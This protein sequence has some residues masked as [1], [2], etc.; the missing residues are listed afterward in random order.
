[1]TIPKISCAR[2]PALAYATKAEAKRMVQARKNWS[3]ITGRIVSVDNGG[4]P[5][6]FVNLQLSIDDVNDRAGFPNM[7]E[8]SR[9]STIDVTAPADRIQ[10]LAL[11]PGDYL[12]AN[13]RVV[14]PNRTFAD[15]DSIARGSSPQ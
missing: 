3:Q 1:M 5:P 9:G 15:P 7:L 10:E 12:S 6:G 2:W 8:G 13:L 4:A 14:G 11:K